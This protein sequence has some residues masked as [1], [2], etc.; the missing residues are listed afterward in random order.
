MLYWLL[1]VASGTC[2][3]IASVLLKVA[4]PI[5]DSISESLPG[6]L[7]YGAAVVV[8]GLGF[9]M[10]A[11]ALKRLPLTL[12]YPVMIAT[13]MIEVWAWGLYSG[14][15]L[16]LRGVLGAGLIVLGAWLIVR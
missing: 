11:I 5:S 1:L 13:T 7:T 6:I 9:V 10:Y 4:A 2:G 15:P 8:Y 16:L 12:A 3:A 14:E